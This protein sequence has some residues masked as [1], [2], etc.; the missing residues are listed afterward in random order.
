MGIS[1][2][3]AIREVDYWRR[4]GVFKRQLILRLG[5]CGRTHPASRDE[6]AP[7][8]YVSVTTVASPAEKYRWIRQIQSARGSRPCR[9]GQALARDRPITFSVLPSSS[10][11]APAAWKR[12][13]EKY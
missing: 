9:T 1:S 6:N 8:A 5:T 2:Y 11:P 10:S 4:R 3:Y 13:P 7:K 12:F